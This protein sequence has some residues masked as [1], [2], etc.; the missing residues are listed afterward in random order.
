MRL[1]RQ[2]DEPLTGAHLPC[3]LACV[4][5]SRRWCR[6]TVSRQFPES[7]TRVL[8]SLSHITLS[9]IPGLYR[10]YRSPNLTSFLPFNVPLNQGPF[11]PPAL[12]GFLSA[13]GLSAAL[14]RPACP[15]PD[16]RLV[17]TPQTTRRGLPVLLRL[18][19]C[20]RAGVTTPAE[21]QGACFALFPWS[22]Q[23]SSYYRR[24][25][26]GIGTFE[27]CPAFTHVAAHM[28]AESLSDPLHRRLH[29]L[30]H[31]HDCFVCCRLKRKL[32]GE[33]CTH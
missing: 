28:L 32:P 30:R 23:P 5:Q 20:M 13:T 17:R 14:A 7:W 16:A 29:L 18:S 2:A 19:S 3:R 6:S 4:S 1:L 31:L 25:G 10:V 27:A 33:T 26:F 9:A 21:A 8:P 24:V 15:S 12:P 11:P 22:W